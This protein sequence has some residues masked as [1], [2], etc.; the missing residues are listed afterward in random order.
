MWVAWFGW[1][2]GTFRRGMTALS[3]VCSRW[4]E[5]E[6]A[7]RLGSGKVYGDWLF[8]SKGPFSK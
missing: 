5:W 8:S 6:E 7:E 3:A 1:I 4:G 2:S